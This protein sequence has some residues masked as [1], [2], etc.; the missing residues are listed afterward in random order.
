MPPA[1][2]MLICAKQEKVAICSRGNIVLILIFAF[3][4]VSLVTSAEKLVE[5]FTAV[6]P[7]VAHGAAVR[8]FATSWV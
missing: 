2:Y 7:A 1:F 4:F 8:Y 5:K 6:P 3:G